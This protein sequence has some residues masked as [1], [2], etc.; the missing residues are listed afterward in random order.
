MLRDLVKGM[1]GGEVFVSEVMEGGLLIPV[2]HEDIEF[3][4]GQEY[5]IG[6][7]THNDQTVKLFIMNSY[8]LRVL[9]SNILVYCEF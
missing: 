9:D 4:V 2:N 6:Y 5:T 3:T 1:I 8:I 7:E